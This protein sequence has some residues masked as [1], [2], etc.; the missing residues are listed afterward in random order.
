MLM[1]SFRKFCEQ[2]VLL[3]QDPM[4]GALPGGGPGPGMGDPMGGMPPGGGGAPMMPPGGGGAMPGMGAD[5]MG[6][7]GMGAPPAAGLKPPMKIEPLSVW[8]VMSKILRGK[9][10]KKNPKSS[11]VDPNVNSSPTPNLLQSSQP[12]A[13]P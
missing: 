8:S 1:E 5:P 13:I 2:K 3:E 6:G 10:I 4:Q 12:S 7:M 9:S 11:G